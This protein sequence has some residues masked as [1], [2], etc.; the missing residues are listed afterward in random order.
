MTAATAPARA[1]VAGL[2]P[3]PAAP[4]PVAVPTPTRVATPAIT[5][6]SA[7]T[8]R[9]TAHVALPGADGAAGSSSR[10]GAA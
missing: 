7:R 5:Q 2:E 10:S 3:E 4:A 6:F 8:R 9:R 1:V